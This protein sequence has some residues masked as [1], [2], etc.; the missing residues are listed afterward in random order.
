MYRRDSLAMPAPLPPLL[1]QRLSFEFPVGEARGGVPLF[2]PAFGVLVWGEGRRVRL[3]LIRADEPGVSAP[4]GA[5]DADA[6]RL[7]LGRVDL[8]LPEDWSVAAGGLH[9][10]TGE[11]ELEL[12]G[13]RSAAKLRASV[14]RE[15]PVLCLRITGLDGAAVR[16]LSLPPDAPDLVERFRERGMPPAQVFDLGTF[17]GWVQECPGGPTTCAGWLCHA[18]AGG[19][20]LYLTGVRGAEPQDA[21]RQALHTLETANATGYTPA[22]LRTFSWWRRWWELLSPPPEDL[23]DYLTGYRRAGEAA[24]LGAVGQDDA[25]APPADRGGCMPGWMSV[26][27]DWKTH[28]TEREAKALEIRRKYNL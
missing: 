18:S 11:A 14:L 2:N 9:L 22:T 13:P 8:E 10:A 12:Q 19:L 16:V 21:R 20:L 1:Q 28:L 17:G 3:T 6:F 15:V 7:P 23:P 4:G 26:A 24:D 27:L 5:S 25:E